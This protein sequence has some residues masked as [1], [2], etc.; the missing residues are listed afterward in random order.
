MRPAP[1]FDNIAYTS[2]RSPMREKMS[3]PNPKANRPSMKSY[4][5]YESNQNKTPQ[6][7][8]VD[9]DNLE[10]KISDL[11]TTL[12]ARKAIERDNEVYNNLT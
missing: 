5:L 9:V 11:L 1:S 10:Q 6:H 7:D 12:Q 2:T 8:R 4:E 3:S